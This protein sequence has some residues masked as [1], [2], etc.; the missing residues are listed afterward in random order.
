MWALVAVAHGL[1]SCSSRAPEHGFTSFGAQGLVTPR[2]VGSSL[3]RD[4]IRILCI[5]RQ[6][7]NHWAT[8]EGPQNC[9]A[10]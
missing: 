3:T 7:L 9:I 8:R 6:S 1:R 2:H 10:V 5:A 4:R